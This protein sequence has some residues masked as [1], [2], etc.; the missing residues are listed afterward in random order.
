MKT[1]VKVKVNKIFQTGMKFLGTPYQFGA[2]SFQ[3]TTFDCSSFVHYIYGLHGVTLPRTSRQ[4]ALIGQR[5]PVEEMRPGDLLFFT[6]PKRKKNKGLS[7]V[8]HVAIYIG[9]DR[10]LHT[11]R[12]EKKVSIASLDP[13]W[14][15]VL[16]G[17][18]RVV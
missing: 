6:T 3:V 12:I 8:G 7:R 14:R 4:Q 9:N 15:G 1:E 13:Y 10:I 5:V 11:S 2:P 16:I 18:R 17:V